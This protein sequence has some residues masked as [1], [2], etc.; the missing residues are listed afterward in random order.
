MT[1]PSACLPWVTRPT[2]AGESNPALSIT[3]QK[4]MA[5]ELNEIRN[6]LAKPQKGRQLMKASALQK[7]LRFH[8]E[9]NL[10]SGDIRQPASDFLDWVRGFLPK[11]KYNIFLGLFKFPLSTTAVVDDVYRE[12]E[13]VFH[14]RNSSITYQFS[15]QELLEDWHNYRRAKLNEPLVWHKTAWKRMQVSPNSVLV[16]DL[17]REQSGLRPEPYFYFL[18]VDDIIDYETVD[19]TQLKW[20]AFKQ[21]KDK[22]AVFDDEYIRVFNC[23]EGTLE[24]IGVDT[25]TAHGLGYCPA[26]FF[27]QS[28]VNEQDKEVKQNP[29]TKELSNLDWLLFFSTSKRHLDLYAPYPI[30]SA[31]EADCNYSNN[32]TGDY[33]DGGFL[34]NAKG[35]YKVLADGS[36]EPCPC[37]SNRRI[38]GPGSFLEIPV[39]NV[40]DGV[41]DLHQPVTITTVDDKSLAYN[42]DECVRLR[43]EIINE[44][45]GVGGSVSEKEAINET[46]VAANFEAKTA[47]L[48]NL[49]TN[50]ESAQKFVDDTVCRLRYGEAFISSNINWGTEFYVFTI[51]ELYDKFKKAKDN[52]ASEAELDSLSQQIIEVEYKND[53]AALAR[54]LLLKQ[55]EPYPHKTMSEVLN[56]YE[57]GLLDRDKV[58]LKLN[59]I[60]YIDKFER[61]NINIVNFGENLSMSEKVERISKKLKE[62]VK[63]ER[64]TETPGGSGQTGG[65]QE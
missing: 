47:V 22:V 28:Q 6:F 59:F 26:R 52:G 61:E 60:S 38:A 16:V 32:E 34:R 4:K 43:N 55:L 36:L 56:L 13:R 40:Q 48:L 24:I 20:I 54:M 29:L 39:P 41:A 3:T 2:E 37:C 12:L 30:Y 21:P 14:S 7:R 31:Y 62:Y 46:Q 51:D 11:D 19:G 17:P 50:F 44:V 63:K 8:T 25:Q 42:V 35:E 57:K 33:C 45:V 27:W 58:V 1:M 23:K 64:F 9:T 15:S 18:E 49:K 5:L 53:P 65:G 10:S